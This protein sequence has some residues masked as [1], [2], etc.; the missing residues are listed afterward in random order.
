MLVYTAAKMAQFG[1]RF[2]VKLHPK[3]RYFSDTYRAIIL[4]RCNFGCNF[5]ETSYFVRQ[6]LWLTMLF[7]A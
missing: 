7:C 2:C 6:A 5:S 3:E 1:A 4:L